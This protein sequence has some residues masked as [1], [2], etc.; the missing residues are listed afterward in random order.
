[1]RKTVAI[2]CNIVGLGWATGLGLGWLTWSRS[3]Y[4]SGLGLLGKQ[5]LVSV[6]DR[7]GPGIVRDRDQNCPGP[8]TGTQEYLV[9]VKNRDFLADFSALKFNT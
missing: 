4:K 9:L 1:M 2:L 7:P 8:G 3:R 6:R 5:I